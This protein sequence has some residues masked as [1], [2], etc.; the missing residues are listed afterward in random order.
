MRSG[1]AIY[2]ANAPSR[3][4]LA[5]RN[6]N[7][8]APVAKIHF[9]AAAIDTLPA[10]NRR[11]EGD[12]VA[13]LVAGDARAH[14]RNHAGCFMSHHQWRN[15]PSR[16]SIV[17]MHI[18]P[19][20]SARRHAH[21]HLLIARLRPRH[22]CNGKLSVC[23][24]QQRFHRRGSS[25]FS[26]KLMQKWRSTFSDSIRWAATQLACSVRC[27]PQ[28][29]RPKTRWPSPQEGPM[30]PNYEANSLQL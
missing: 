15:A 24:Q 2:S 13:R 11:I 18:A 22:F 7:H 4:I 9:S 12:P 10:I 16:R 6:A 5:A 17:P 26:C 8:L 1:T 27:R 21:Q 29:W 14:G 3:A 28:P 19:A 23:F 25:T 20:D 30:R